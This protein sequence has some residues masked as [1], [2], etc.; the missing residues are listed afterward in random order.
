MDGSLPN[1]GSGQA[2]GGVSN[3]GFPETRTP[4]QVALLCVAT[5]GLYFFVWLGRQRW[6][7]EN[8]LKRNHRHPLTWLLVPVPIA[9]LVVT[10]GAADVIE[11]GVRVRNESAGPIAFWLY[12]LVGGMP[13]APWIM[14]IMQSYVYF[15]DMDQ[16]R[17]A[18]IPLTKPR[19]NA[20]EIM[21]IVIGTILEALVV[22]SQFG[23]DADAATG[24]L[25]LGSFAWLT[26]LAIF[27]VVTSRSNAK[28]LR[29]YTIKQCS[30][31]RSEIPNDAA[32]CRYCQRDVVAVSSEDR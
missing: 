26:S 27:A 3:F 28:I 20:Y 14:P 21:A 7:A 24:Y 30:Y 25:I 8:V 22:F 32:V 12:T 10:L 19:L 2:V 15:A 11:H 31:C 4:F 23:T 17:I 1:S 13:L 6:L 18:G 5:F 29:Y 16:R 9:N